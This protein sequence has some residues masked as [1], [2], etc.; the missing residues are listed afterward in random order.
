MQETYNVWRTAKVARRTLRL[1]ASQGEE[2]AIKELEA[3]GLGAAEMGKGVAKGKG[4]SKTDKRQQNVGSKG[5]KLPEGV[6]P[7]GLH[8]V[9]KINDR[10]RHNKDLVEKRK[11][12]TESNLREADRLEAE[13]GR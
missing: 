8:A 1:R 4:V 13:Q 3:M 9:G 5:Q 10:S 7:G 2:E 11:G 12:M 6:L